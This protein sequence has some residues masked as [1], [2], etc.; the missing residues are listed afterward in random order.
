[1]ET[2]VGTI[3]L[4][5]GKILMVKEAKEKCYGKWA[6]PAGHIEP[7]EA[8]YDGAKRET[9]EETGCTVELK[10]AFPVFLKNTNDSKIVM[11]HFLSDLVNEEN[12]Y[13]KDEILET[14][15]ISIDEIK[16]MDEKEFR[17]SAVVK[18]IINDIE[19]QNLYDLEIV[20]DMPQ[21]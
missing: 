1:M 14:K 15:W 20:K 10:K 18:Q 13:D 9:Y 21:I 17:S 11:M 16:N 6:F 3:I 12:S 4:K 7:N 2:I 5:D 8:I 19:K